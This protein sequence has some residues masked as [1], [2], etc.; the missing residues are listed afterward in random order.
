[1]A[2]LRDWAFNNGEPVPQAEYY[3]RAQQT[4]EKPVG[5][6]HWLTRHVFIGVGERRLDGNHVRYYALT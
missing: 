3:L 6:H 4:I 1:M 5:K 2:R